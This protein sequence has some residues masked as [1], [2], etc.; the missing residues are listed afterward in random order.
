MIKLYSRINCGLAPCQRAKDV[1]GRWLYRSPLT[2]KQESLLELASENDCLRLG[3]CI[4][5]VHAAEKKSNAAIK[6]KFHMKTFPLCEQKLHDV[7]PP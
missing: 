6:L 7:E 3:E 1:I 4:S 2:P 5:K